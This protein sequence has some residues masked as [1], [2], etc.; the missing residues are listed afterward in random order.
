MRGLQLLLLYASEHPPPPPPHT[1]TSTCARTGGRAGAHTKVGCTLVKARL[2]RVSSARVSRVKRP[3]VA[4]QA[5]VCQVSSARVSRVKRP[6][7]ACQAPVCQVSSARVSRVKRPCVKPLCPS[8]AIL[9]CAQ[10]RRQHGNTRRAAVAGRLGKAR[11]VASMPR[12]CAR[13]A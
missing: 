1:H 4:C 3:C 2:V 10:W 7:V 13:C 11:G 12:L 9:P 8:M 6:C 5:P